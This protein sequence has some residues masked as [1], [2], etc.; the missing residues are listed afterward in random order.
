MQFLFLL[1]LFRL[2]TEHN[3]KMRLL[4]SDQDHQLANSWQDHRHLKHALTSSCVCVVCVCA[5]Y[6]PFVSNGKHFHRAFRPLLLWKTTSELQHSCAD[7]FKTQ[8]E[9]LENVGRIVPS[10]LLWVQYSE[11]ICST[12]DPAFCLT[13][14]TGHWAHPPC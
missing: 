5:R 4:A 1:A 7:Q 9:P 13:Q 14:R 11:F 2:C 8:T 6:S 3:A 12:Q 10:P